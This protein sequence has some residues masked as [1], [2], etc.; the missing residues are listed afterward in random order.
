MMNTLN[1]LIA[2]V[3]LIVAV[4]AYQRT[5]GTK[6]LRKNTA[7]LLTKMEKK[8]REEV[9]AKGEDEKIQK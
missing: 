9:V 8:I 3:A 2:I 4:I 1:F 7:E 5:G 6:E